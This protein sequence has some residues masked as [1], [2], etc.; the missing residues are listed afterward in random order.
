ML[1]KQT[2]AVTHTI[3]TAQRVTAPLTNVYTRAVLTNT[4]GHDLGDC[5]TANV[6]VSITRYGSAPGRRNR[7]R[8][9]LAGI[10]VGDISLGKILPASQASY[11][12]I[13]AAMTGIKTLVAGHA[14]EMGFWSPAH[15]GMVNG[16]PVNYPAQFV[17]T[18][19]YV[20]RDTIRVQRSR[21]V[22]VGS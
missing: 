9:A 8:I 7:G 12:N 1:D 6:A 10:P 15:I 17:G 11:N 22:G 14:V 5:D 18:P 3:W 13:G 19:S 21:T 4:T 2:Q 20:V 16:Q